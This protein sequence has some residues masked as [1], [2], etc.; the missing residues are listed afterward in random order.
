MTESLIS[1]PVRRVC[2]VVLVSVVLLAGCK[3]DARV[4][5]RVKADG[6]GTVTATVTLDAA[7]VRRIASGSSLEKAVRLDDMRAAG[8]NVTVLATSIQG[9]QGYRIV[10]THPFTGQ[11][12]LANRLEDLGGANGVLGDPKIKRTRSWFGATDSVQIN[13]DLRNL[14]T[15][16]RSDPGVAKALTDAGVN[17]AALDA[18]LRGEL[19]KSVTLTLAVHAPNGETSEVVVKPGA[20]GAADAQSSNFYA[21]RVVLLVIGGILLLLAIVL[22]AA[23]LLAKSRRHHAS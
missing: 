12:D 16:I 6:S 19:G 22:M 7:A 1:T 11:Q 5:V 10:L 2:G 18:Q 14:S 4:D 13:A 3:V 9:D 17:V 20:V 23:S 21:Q 15:G 8:W